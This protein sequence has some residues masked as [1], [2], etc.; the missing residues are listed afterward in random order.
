MIRINRQIHAAYEIR[1]IRADRWPPESRSASARAAEELTYQ[2]HQRQ[3]VLA[4]MQLD[5]R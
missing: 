4:A 5:R 2:W 1:S 3:R